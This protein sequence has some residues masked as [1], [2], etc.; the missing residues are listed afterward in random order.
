MRWEPGLTVVGMFTNTSSRDTSTTTRTT[1][2][3][4]RSLGPRVSDQERNGGNV[5]G[6]PFAATWYRDTGWAIPRSR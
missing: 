3:S 2:L 4:L 5:A 1:S 6:R